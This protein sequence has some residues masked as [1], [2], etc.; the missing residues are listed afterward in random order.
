MLEETNDLMSKQT[1]SLCMKI[2][3]YEVALQSSPTETISFQ[4]R[5]IVGLEEQNKELQQQHKEV[6][7]QLIDLQVARQMVEMKMA[8]NEGDVSS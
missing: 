4:Q 1:E 3:E 6:L 2:K 5:K 8:E 7:T